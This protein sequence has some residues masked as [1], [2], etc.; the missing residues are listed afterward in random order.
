MS[1]S[2]WCKTLL[3]RLPSATCYVVVFGTDRV[4]NEYVS[5]PQAPQR[6]QTVVEHMSN[7]LHQLA[8]LSPRV[9]IIDWEWYART[10]GM[11]VYRD[12]RLWYLARM[13]LNPVGLA[14][15]AELVAQHVCASRGSSRKVAVVDLDNTLWGGV[16]GEDG[17]PGLILGEEGLGLAFKDFQ[18]E[19]LKLYN[20][21]IVLALCSKN[22]PEDVSNV[23]DKHPDMALRMEHFAAVRINWNDKATNLEELSDELSLGLDSFVF[24]DDS[25]V[26]REWVRKA[27]P[28]V[29]VPELAEDPV[30]RPESLRRSSFFQRIK[31]TDAD[32]LRM[33]SYKSQGFRA[34]SARSLC[35][36]G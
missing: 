6:G 20:S 26:E 17:L 30:Y 33:E 25:Q 3:D 35:K 8:D 28:E 5:H 11:A 15:L 27:L 16:V 14:T 12:E 10:N 36:L 19:L 13:R 2:W 23:F 18:R 21:G 7:A 34:T 31:L 24:F 4:L 22:N 29:L 1:W 9:V 32:T